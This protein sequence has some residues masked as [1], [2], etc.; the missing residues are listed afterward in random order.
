MGMS[1]V[2]TLLS[3]GVGY[4]LIGAPRP[5]SIRGPTAPRVE[6]SKVLVADDIVIDYR[7]VRD[8]DTAVAI[9]GVGFPRDAFK[10]EE[11]G[12]RDSRLAVAALVG[13]AALWGTN[14]PAVRYLLEDGTT[15]PAAYA[16]AR[17]GVAAVALAPFLPRASCRGALVA[18]AECGAW[19]AAGR[20]PA[21]DIDAPRA[22][23]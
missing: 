17:F 12:E 13:V 5:V 1:W 22:P 23:R 14:F 8:L 11:E 18:G 10:E 4:A 3:A 21:S 19:I 16:V 7:H 6:R 15:S 20:R 2:L 9:G